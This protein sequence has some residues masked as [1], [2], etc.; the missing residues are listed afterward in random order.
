[1]PEDTEAEAPEAE[2][3]PEP[4]PEVEETYE[5]WVDDDYK[6]PRAR[7]VPRVGDWA[8]RTWKAIPH[9]GKKAV[10]LEKKLRGSKKFVWNRDPTKL[11]IRE[12]DLEENVPLHVKGGPARLVFGDIVEL[13]PD[14]IQKMRPYTKDGS[15]GPRRSRPVRR[16][17]KTGQVV[18]ED[19]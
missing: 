16:S 6:H 2:P 8:K 11:I 1:M 9:E 14:L 18:V 10:V 4:V 7:K 12:I 17:I 5:D 13:T 15:L 19:A 3:E